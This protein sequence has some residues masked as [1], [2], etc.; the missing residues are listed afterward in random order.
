MSILDR[1]TITGADDSVRP[2]DLLELSREFPF[3]EWGHPRV[4]K[5][6]P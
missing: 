5:R 3:V 2:T 1:V 6:V 4:E